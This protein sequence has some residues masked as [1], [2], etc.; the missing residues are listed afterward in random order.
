MAA[1]LADGRQFQKL[2]EGQTIPHRPIPL[3]PLTDP[4]AQDL[5]D[6]QLA[7]HLVWNGISLREARLWQPFC[8][9]RTTEPHNDS[10]PAPSSF[11]EP[12][13]TDWSWIP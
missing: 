9:M 10:V 12:V 6:V 5:T 8:V 11:T 13:Q 2:I 3:L 4:N 1:L 7:A